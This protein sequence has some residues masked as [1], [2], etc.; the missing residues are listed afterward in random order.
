M[1]VKVAVVG[2]SGYTGLEL[3]RLLARHPEVEIAAV[4]SREYAG[5]PLRTVFYRPA[6]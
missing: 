4:T 5:Q 3:V 6:P 1:M 2:A